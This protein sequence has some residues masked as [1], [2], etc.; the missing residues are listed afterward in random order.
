MTENDELTRLQKTERAAMIGDRAAVLRIISAL[1][2]Y[3]QAAKEVIDSQWSDGAID[4][5]CANTFRFTVEEIEN[6]G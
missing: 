6:D 5:A 1:I 3:R 4:G 2:R